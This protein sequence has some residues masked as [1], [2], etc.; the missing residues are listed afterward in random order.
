MSNK[1]TRKNH[2]SSKV[3]FLLFTG[4]L[5]QTT[6]IKRVFVYLWYKIVGMYLRVEEIVMYS[7][8]SMFR[9]QY[10]THTHTHTHTHTYTQVNSHTERHIYTQRHTQTHAS[11]S[12]HTERHTMHLCMHPCTDRHNTES[13][14]TEIHMLVTNTYTEIYI[15]HTHIQHK[16]KHI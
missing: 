6:H 2:N 5:K 15:T 3:S 1:S 14:N 8:D 4:G 12:V 11:T 13:K 7:W 9:I 10:W 16:H